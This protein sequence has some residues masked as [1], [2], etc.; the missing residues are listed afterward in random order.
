MYLAI[1]SFA[2]YITR[3]NVGLNVYRFL[4]GKWLFDVI[5]TGLIIK[6][7]I[8]LGHIISKT[9]D[10][11]VIELIGPFGLTTSLTITAHQIARYDT[12]LVTTYS[13]YMV[14]GLLS[15]IFYVFVLGTGTDVD[16]S[17]IIV[18]LI[19]LIYVR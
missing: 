18:F 8:T 7:G 9:L 10:R 13:L 6:Q 14:L 1:P 11:G 19:S 3:N 17:L 4:I 16:L 2:I 5:I 12:G 15:I